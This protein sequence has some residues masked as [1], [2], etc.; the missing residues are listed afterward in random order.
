MSHMSNEDD[1]IEFVR[2]T[3]GILATELL[4]DVGNE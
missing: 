2:V 1:G 4:F 3:L